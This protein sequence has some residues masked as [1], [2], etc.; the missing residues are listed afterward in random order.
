MAA[1][2]WEVQSFLALNRF[3]AAVPE[4][5]CPWSAAV[6]LRLASALPVP[7]ESHSLVIEAQPEVRLESGRVA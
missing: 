5:R 7:I 4:R 1:D 6:D 2:C 3:L